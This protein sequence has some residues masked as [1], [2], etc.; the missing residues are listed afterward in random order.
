MDIYLGHHYIKHDFG[1]VNYP[2]IHVSANMVG[3][4]K[5]GYQL[6][7]SPLSYRCFGNDGQSGIYIGNCLVHECKLLS[8]EVNWYQSNISKIKNGNKKTLK[9]LH[10]IGSKISIIEKVIQEIKLY[11]FSA[12]IHNKNNGCDLSGYQVKSCPI[13]SS[14]LHVD[15]IDYISINCNRASQNL[16]LGE[17]KLSSNGLIDHKR[18]LNNYNEGIHDEEFIALMLF[19][20]NVVVNAIKNVF[21]I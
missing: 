3:I 19:M 6:Q 8:H 7:S 20:K 1:F 18:V 9:E 15:G 14:K 13:V 17:M 11:D 12:F 5:M 21:S 10:C 4:F 16:V 2:Y